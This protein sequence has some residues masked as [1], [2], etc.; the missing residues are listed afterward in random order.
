[1]Q[2]ARSRRRSDRDRFAAPSARGDNEGV[3]LLFAHAI[4]FL[5]VTMSVSA[6][7]LQISVIDSGST[8]FLGVTVTVD[9]SGNA[10]VTQ[11]GV[12]P[13][14][15]KLSVQLAQQLIDD[16]KAAGTLSALPEQHCAKSASFGSSLYV[17]F[18]GDRSPDISCSPQSDPR[19]AALQKDANDI[20]QAVRKQVK[21]QAR[22]V[23]GASPPR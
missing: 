15:T 21:L 8:N 3:R 7:S 23:R 2:L 11:P 10:T 4:G 12:P 5:V 17:E 19:S 22:R 20:L 1:M 13:Q 6:N 16:A 18:N 14:S 9:Q